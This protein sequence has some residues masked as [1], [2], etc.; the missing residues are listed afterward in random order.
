[1]RFGV[2]AGAQS[3]KETVNLSKAA[4]RYGFDFVWLPDENP[5]FP[6]RDFIVSLTAIASNTEF[7]NIGCGVTNPYS[8]HIAITGVQF[9]S[10]AELCGGRTVV[11]GLSCGGPTPL[12][13]LGIK[14]WEKPMSTLR[15]SVQ[16]LRKLFR[17]EVVNYESERTKLRNVKLFGPVDVP[18]Y[19]AARG[20]MMSKLAGEIADGVILNPPLELIPYAIENIKMGMQIA[21]KTEFDFV[22]YVPIVVSRNFEI[23]RP[24]ATMMLWT[25]P[26]FIL[27]KM[28]MQK[29]AEEV[30]KLV[31]AVG[32]TEE[33]VKFITDDILKSFVIAGTPDQC[34]ETI[35]KQMDFGVTQLAFMVLPFK[36][37][38]PIPDLEGTI[39]KIGKEII[40]SFK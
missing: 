22:H 6:Y 17:G 30:G 21:K 3:I 36:S 15:D 26:S 20:P 23:M 7:I 24:M 40:P 11:F 14:M 12:T 1:M 34:I 37:P 33:S 31:K 27:E 8:R 38:V 9:A 19:L 35:Q 16:I 4:E 28:G 5:A 32:Y 39:K 10:L 2:V 25:A 13:P 18:I 29:L